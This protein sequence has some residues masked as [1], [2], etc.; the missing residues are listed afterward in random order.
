MPGPIAE[1]IEQKLVAEFAPV[2]LSVRDQSD[3]HRGHAGAAGRTETH[4]RVEI[5][6]ASFEGMSRVARERLVQS[7][8]GADLVEYVHALSVSARTP[9]EE[10]ISSPPLGYGSGV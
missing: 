6:S 2:R 10:N 7:A 5:V 3:A 1:K 8:L 4:F 9:A